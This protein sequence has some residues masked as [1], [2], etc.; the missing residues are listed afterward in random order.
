MTQFV[1]KTTRLKTELLK[2]E[3]AFDVGSMSVVYNAIVGYSTYMK[4]RTRFRR[5]AAFASVASSLGQCFS[6]SELRRSKK[7]FVAVLK[8]AF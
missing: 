6:N 5:L 3:F 2:V 4:S 7:F 1:P 8:R